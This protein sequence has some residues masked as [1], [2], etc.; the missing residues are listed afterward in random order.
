MGDNREM[1]DVSLVDLEVIKRYSLAIRQENAPAEEV[2]AALDASRAQVLAALDQ[3]EDPP[4]PTRR[5]R[6]APPESLPPESLPPEPPVFAPRP[7]PD[8]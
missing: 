4:R 5:R 1:S 6:P 8:E 2:L 7:W 3:M